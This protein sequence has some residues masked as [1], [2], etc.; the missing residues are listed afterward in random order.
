MPSSH[1]DAGS[2]RSSAATARIEAQDLAMGMP[3][4]E[5]LE[6]Y[7]CRVVVNQSVEESLLYVICVGESDF[8]KRFFAEN[9][10]PT[11]KKLAIIYEGDDTNLADVRSLGIKLYFVDPRPLTAEQT[12][13]IFSFFFID[14]GASIDARKELTKPKQ[15]SVISKEASREQA[16]S[17]QGQML[18]DT[19]RIAKTMRQ[20][21]ESDR[22]TLYGTRSKGKWKRA[23][24][25]VGAGLFIFI[26]PL[27][28]Y[29]AS[30]AIGVT[31]LAMSGKALL[32][33][34]TQWTDTLIHAGTPYLQSAQTMLHLTS[35]IL[36]TIQLGGL[37]D[38]EDRLLSLLMD[39][40]M[41][42][43]GVVTI[44]QTSKAV[45]GTILFP[46]D[47]TQSTSAADVASLSSEVSRVSQHLAL[48]Q[49]ELDSLMSSRRFPFQLASVQG[50]G[51]RGL[52]S[53]GNVRTLIGYT[54]KLLTLYPQMSGFRKKQTYLVL[55]Q[56]SM[57]LRPTGGFIGSLLSVSF[58]DGKVD[59]MHVIDVYTADGQLKGH[60]DPPLPIREIIGQ[61]HWYLRDSNWDPDF[62]VSG[63]Q[64]AWFYEKEMGQTVDG[65]IAVSLPVVTHL[66]HVMGPV[67][68][69]DF[70]ERISES[71]F[72]AKSLLY[73]QTDFFPGSTQKKDFLGALMTALLL[74]MTN[75]RSVSAGQLL[76]SVAD[77]IQARDIQFYF[78]DPAL[79][80]LVTEWGWDGGMNISP[81][82]ILNRESSC[83]GDGVGIIEA[84]LGINKVNY[85]VTR[86][87]LSDITLDDNDSVHQVLT[88]KFHNTT[89]TQVPDGGGAYQMYLRLYYPEGSVVQSIKLD[90]QDVPPRNPQSSVPPPAPYV[91]TDTS[92]GGVVLGV[93][94]A[95]S[96]HQERQL[97]IETTRSLT[98]FVGATSYQFTIR[99]QAGVTTF[100]WH[101][102]V[103]YPASWGAVTDSGI[104]KPGE[105][106]YNTD[107][108]NDMKLHVLFQKPS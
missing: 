50:L 82:Q 26:A 40:S 9:N 1:K 23:I 85:F 65:V 48:V 29:V 63:K 12:K 43:S 34:N 30:F 74:R 19:K 102:V 42:E 76:R 56:N 104:A 88:V 55:L 53:L 8:V 6:R 49:A 52:I 7:G 77:S 91:V 18:A 27:C 107:L 21:F 84:N 46:N 59:D 96:P 13:D 83:I 22:K 47:T 70:N 60:V 92:G 16:P 67:D 54:E 58:V 32:A 79:Q 37:A 20:I 14:K 100:P 17:P 75:D 61:E 41:A 89:P 28:M 57:E 35:P 38:D 10:F 15:T 66:L 11:A 98:P 45:A 62:S 2:E 99:K 106:E 80:Q 87:A 39:A 93:P 78:L 4:R 86:E 105:L 3:L 25:W 95:V 101:V 36:T 64:A 51:R 5:Y 73:T 97:V 103:R 72:F 71:N 108:I 24:R 81:C 68:L 69:S 90:G 44:F 94:F 33:G 31:L